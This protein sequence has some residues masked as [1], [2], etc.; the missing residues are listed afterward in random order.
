[1]YACLPPIDSGPQQDSWSQ[2]TG[3]IRG[4]GDKPWACHALPRPKDALDQVH[5]DSSKGSKSQ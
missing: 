3:A 2:S 5:G 4:K 1:M